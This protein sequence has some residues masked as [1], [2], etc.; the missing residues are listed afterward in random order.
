MF[1]Y[2]KEAEKARLKKYR[3]SKIRLL[4]TSLGIDFTGYKKRELISKIVD[5]LFVNLKT[6]N[7]YTKEEICEKDNIAIDYSDA[8]AKENLSSL[9][10]SEWH[11]NAVY[12]KDVYSGFVCD[13][14]LG[15]FCVENP[16]TTFNIDE[17]IK[18]PSETI[19]KHKLKVG[20]FLEIYKDTNEIFGINR[21][22]VDVFK[23]VLLEKLEVEQSNK[24]L[25]FGENPEKVPL[26]F[27]LLQGGKYML[28]TKKE[29]TCELTKRLIDSL[30]FSHSEYLI[31][32]ITDNK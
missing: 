22:P 32:L 9:D 16:F 27:T 25:D 24:V 31:S 17:C 19:K 11:K 20:D 15:C 10:F 29:L 18:L 14:N 23:R 30:N 2:I 8:E 5:C 28:C 12:G 21:R 6:D 4:A 13:L 3:L 1:E 26:Q 7:D